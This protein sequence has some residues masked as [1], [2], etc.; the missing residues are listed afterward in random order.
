LA[1]PR[2][3]FVD[4]KAIGSGAHDDQESGWYKLDGGVAVRILDD[5]NAHHI[6]IK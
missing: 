6:E 3:V 1:G 2:R 4:G 5:G